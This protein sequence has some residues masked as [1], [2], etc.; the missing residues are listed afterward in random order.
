[1]KAKLDSVEI[2]ITEENLEIKIL[3]E[4][5]EFALGTIFKEGVKENGDTIMDDEQE[6]SPGII[7]KDDSG[8]D[9]ISQGSP[10]GNDGNDEEEKSG[11]K[12][13][14]KIKIKKKKAKNDDN[15]SCQTSEIGIC[16]RQPNCR[17]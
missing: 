17:A 12:K 7:I 5:L 9:T 2:Q 6:K 3:F 4:K 8:I 11:K 16:D 14:K 10:D 1:M 15:K 13:K